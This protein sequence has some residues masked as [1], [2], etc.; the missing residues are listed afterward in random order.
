MTFL[1]NV[2]ILVRNPDIYIALT[3]SRKKNMLDTKKHD[4]FFENA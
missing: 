2:I 3:V 4:L 1:R